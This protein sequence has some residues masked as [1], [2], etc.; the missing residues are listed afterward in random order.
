MPAFKATISRS[1]TNSFGVSFER[2]ARISTASAERASACAT[3]EISSSSLNG[4]SK[5]STAP[6]FIVSIPMRMLSCPPTKTMC[7]AL[8]CSVCCLWR[9]SPSNPR[10]S[11]TKTHLA[12][13]VARGPETGQRRRRSPQSSRSS[14]ADRRGSSG[15]TVC[16]LPRRRAILTRSC[17]SQTPRHCG[18]RRRA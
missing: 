4:F 12:R 18:S 17:F 11:A 14:P 16:H 6:R 3:A 8:P 10:V 7:S 1:T 2:R 13:D 9:A 15:A 5:K